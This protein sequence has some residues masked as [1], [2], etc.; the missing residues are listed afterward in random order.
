MKKHLILAILSLGC[1]FSC[2]KSDEDPRLVVIT[3]DGFRW[4]EI[5]NGAD[6]T[7]LNSLDFVPET[8][9][10]NQYF[11]RESPK[12]A[13]ELLYPFLWSSVREHGYILGNRSLGCKV[14]DANDKWY[15]YPCYCEMF[16]GL[17]DNS[18]DTNNPVENV[19]HNVLEAANRDPRY[20]GSVMALTSWESIRWAFANER[21]GI[22]ASSGRE[23]CFLQT[24]QTAM[25]MG[26]DSGFPDLFDYSERHDLV[27]Y[28]YAMEIL[29][30]LHPKVFYIGFGDTDV[31]GHAK[32]YDSYLRTAQATDGYI[33]Q[34][35][36]YCESDPFYKGRTTYM[37][38]CDHGRGQ[39]ISCFSGHGRSCPGSGQI[40]FAAFGNKVPV[41]GEV[42]QEGQYYLKQLAPTIASVLSIDY[43]PDDGSKCEAFPIN[44]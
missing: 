41:L 28:G 26:F 36:E 32:K 37:I 1:L 17:A 27:T 11:R 22:P 14:D 9:E 7:L 23:P 19:H 5:F 25:L 16:S 33:R 10:L 6:T 12:E 15:S 35:V 44:K 42:A 3:I 40:W 34:I 13:R 29:K 20:K 39:D 38:L 2:T 30:E 43:A 4:Q 21:A 31:W 8:W 18:I 24:P